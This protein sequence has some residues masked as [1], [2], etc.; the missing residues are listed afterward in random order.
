[1]KDDKLKRKSAKARPPALPAPIANLKR[2]RRFTFKEIIEAVEK[3]VELST[4]RKGTQAALE[5]VLRAAH[6]TDAI[7]QANSFVAYVCA[8]SYR[9]E[10]NTALGV[11]LDEQKARRL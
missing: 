5:Y 8:A 1:M 2:R 9:P 6:G 11:F 7:N 3:I 4:D 10:F